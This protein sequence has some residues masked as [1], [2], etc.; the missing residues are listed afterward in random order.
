MVRAFLPGSA[1]CCKK[2]EKDRL[3]VA[4]RKDDHS[5]S[6]MARLPILRDLDQSSTQREGSRADQPPQASA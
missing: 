3:K 2:D 6:S 1:F 5:E 4:A